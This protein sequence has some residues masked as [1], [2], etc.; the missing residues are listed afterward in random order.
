MAPMF[1]K[2]TP[3][4]SLPPQCVCVCVR[5][6]VC[7]WPYVSVYLRD[8]ASSLGHDALVYVFKQCV[9][10]RNWLVPVLAKFFVRLART[11]KFVICLRFKTLAPCWTKLNHAECSWY[12]GLHRCILILVLNS[13]KITI[14]DT[15]VSIWIHLPDLQIQSHF[16]QATWCWSPVQPTPCLLCSLPPTKASFPRSYLDKNHHESS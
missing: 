15:S 7:V 16:G 12:K 2:V 1:R 6:C 10:N 11:S 8:L 13:S 14:L 5:V 3:E 9:S 4:S